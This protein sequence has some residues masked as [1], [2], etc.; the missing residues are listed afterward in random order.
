M[1]RGINFRDLVY[2]MTCLSLAIVVGGAVYEHLA[3][4]PRWTRAIPASLSM[5]QGES[6]LYPQAF[7]I[8]VHPITTA[9]LGAALLTSWKLKRCANV[10]VAL[11]GYLV[12][13]GVTFVYFVPELIEL[14]ATPYS[15]SVDAALTE[16]AQRWETLSLVRLFALML[17]SLVLFLGL[18][19][20]PDGEN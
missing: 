10:L 6:G 3:V 20:G 18:A 5:F 9:L 4:V 13:L 11:L 16:R 15:Q 19:K 7:W 14:T 1:I 8:P 12:I 2:A 17:L